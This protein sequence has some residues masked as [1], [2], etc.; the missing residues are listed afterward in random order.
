V[1]S[2]VTVRQVGITKSR[3]AEATMITSLA[4]T[5]STASSCR[6]ALLSGVVASTERNC[7]ERL[8]A[9]PNSFEASRSP[10]SEWLPSEWLPKENW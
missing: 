1:S 8:S 6:S 4:S 3:Q 5:T 7:P 2:G 10:H 9:L